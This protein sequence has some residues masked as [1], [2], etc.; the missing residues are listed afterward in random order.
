MEGAKRLQEKDRMFQALA[1]Q[2][3]TTP[4]MVSQKLGRM[5]KQLKELESYSQVR[6]FEIVHSLNYAKI[7]I[8]Y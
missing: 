3:S 6:N 2:L 5:D 8:T 7:L 1:S 4:A